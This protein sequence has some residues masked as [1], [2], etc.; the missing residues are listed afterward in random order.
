MLLFIFPREQTHIQ[1]HPYALFL[2]VEVLINICYLKN[3]KAGNVGNKEHI[4]LH[5]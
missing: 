3:G 1:Q 4:Y 2:W 5:S